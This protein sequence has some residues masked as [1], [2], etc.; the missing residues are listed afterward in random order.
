MS[1]LKR[2]FTLIELLVVIAIIAILAAMLLPALNQ[3]REKAK[4][5]SCI[6]NF[7]QI[8]TANHF[9]MGDHDD[10]IVPALA[11]YFRFFDGTAAARPGFELLVAYKPESFKG[12][13]YGISYPGNLSCPS[14]P[15]KFDAAKS[16]YMSYAAT[17][18]N[19]YHYALNC[20]NGMTNNPTT[21]KYIKGDKLKSPSKYRVAMDG[22][23]GIDLFSGVNHRS[24]IGSRH[25]GYYNAV[26]GDGHAAPLVLRVIGLTDTSTGSSWEPNV[27]FDDGINN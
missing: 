22:L 1:P 18:G 26:M 24:K 12:L 23:Y 14:L 13:N 17:N 27:P 10:Y 2:G 19:P 4:A 8:G 11:S 21:Y 5:S 6:N 20:Y 16:V 3:A 25:S 9:Y 7:K 15:E